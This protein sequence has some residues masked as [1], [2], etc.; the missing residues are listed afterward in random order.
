MKKL[1][2]ILGL[3]LG[4]TISGAQAQTPPAV[5]NGASI[6]GTSP[7]LSGLQV[8]SSTSAG[9]I[10]L[11][12]T[13]ASCTFNYGVT[14][15]STLTFPC[16]TT[17][18]GAVILSGGLTVT[19]NISGSGYAF[20][21]GS[22]SYGATSATVNG[23]LTAT[24]LNSVGIYTNGEAIS[25]DTGA[26][27]GW[28]LW[29]VSNATYGFRFWNGVA[30][31]GPE[32]AQLTS[33]GNFYINPTTAASC[34]ELNGTLNTNCPTFNNTGDGGLRV[35]FNAGSA[36]GVQWVSQTGS[37][38]TQE[39]E[40]TPTGNLLLGP[41]NSNTSCLNL[42]SNFSYNCPVINN[43]S[44]GGMN[45]SISSGSAYGYRFFTTNS[46]G[47][48]TQIAQMDDSGDL[49]LA[50]TESLGNNQNGAGTPALNING[51]VNIQRGST[52]TG[53]I[54]FA[55]N[56]S[57]YE[58]YTGSTYYF[59]GGAVGT[60]NGFLLGNN[61]T[62][63][64][65]ILSE[66]GTYVAGVNCN[67]FIF[68][69]V[70]T[71]NLACIDNSGNMG[72]AAGYY[73]ASQRYLKNN[74][75]NYTGPEALKIALSTNAVRFCYKKEKCKPGETRHIGFIADDT[76][77][78]IAPHHADI[79]IGATAVVALA[80]VKYENQTIQ[81]LQAQVAQQQTEIE[82][83]N[84]R[85]NRQVTGLAPVENNG[86]PGL[87]TSTSDFV[88]FSIAVLGFILLGLMKYRK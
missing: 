56:G 25:N 73:A 41:Q 28:N 63:T 18:S 20:N 21:T 35:G 84:E 62:G 46:T 74:I 4:L 64:P 80:A 26:I 72:I 45:L 7:Q 32:T 9:S 39:G 66:P 23:P 53:V 77:T 38:Y 49:T 5:G 86:R 12:G 69:M 1:L 51:D 24:Q 37:T 44:D 50:G 10:K 19:S 71:A 29:T 55:G 8:N 48:L 54:F 78:D 75:T 36:Y 11:G 2:L 17:I 68:G 82:S 59:S 67:E 13:S 43:S 60:L 76:S 34:I 70:A 16:P 83:I 65:I 6:N 81:T 79:D 33:A 87:G 30:G 52:G 85:L 22:S 40:L 31:T 27:N 14:S 57:D 58:Y 88:I 3:A 47:G 42:N 61:T 15:S